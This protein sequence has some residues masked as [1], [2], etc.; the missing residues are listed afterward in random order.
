MSWEAGFT[1]VVLGGLIFVLAKDLAGPAQSFVAAVVIL[2]VAGVLT[3]GQAFAGFSNPAPITV[4]ALY[5]L[6]RA[7]E[8]TGALQPLVNNVLGQS[9]YMRLPL[10]RLVFPTAAASA[11]L[12]NTPIVAMLVPQVSDWADRRGQSPSKYLMPLSFAAILGGMVTLIGTSTN[13]VIS[14]LLEAAGYEPLGMFELTRV[15]LPIALIGLIAIVALAPRVLTDRRPARS[16][17]SENVREFVVGMTVEAGGPLVGRQVRDAGLRQLQGVFLTELEREGEVIAPVGP[18]TV[19]NANDRLSFVGRADT[20]VDLQAIKGLTST[21]ARHLSAFDSPRHTFFE[22]VV[23]AASPLVG[24]TLKTLEFRSRYQAAVVA[25]HRAGRR[26]RAKLGGVRLEVGDTLLLVSDDGFRDRWRDRTDFLL[27]SMLGGTAPAVSRKAGIVAVVGVGIVGGAALGVLPILHL[28]LLGALVLVGTRV[29]TPDEAK[30]S[31]DLDVI[32]V[33]A[34]AFG[35][36]AALDASGLAEASAHGLRAVF[37]PMG[38]PG[39]LFGLVIATVVLK[40]VVTNN[41]AAALMFPIAVSTAAE[42][43]VDVRPFAIGVA[44]AASASFLTPVSY[45]TNLMVY[46]PGGYRFGDYW[47]LGGVLGVIVVVGVLGGVG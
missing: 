11:F 15:A 29:L 31:V 1:L 17:V 16:D 28:S 44:L 22:A 39:L 27:V 32:I 45:Q 14:G 12:N 5:V 47:R 25:I 34:S 41:A 7:V 36:A 35:L 19:L 13:L 2:L 20:V 42:L 18:D 10:L 38:M 26:V 24:K 9:G 4:A 37:G 43:G 21:E 33:I 6:A 40:S 23:G 8:K 30:T 46:G 3:P